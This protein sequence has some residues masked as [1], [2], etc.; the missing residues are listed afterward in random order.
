[1]KDNFKNLNESERLDYLRRKSQ[2]KFIAGI[3]HYSFTSPKKDD[4]VILIPN[5]VNLFDRKAVQVHN[6]KLEQM[7]H[8]NKESNRFVFDLLKGQ[9]AYAKIRR[10]DVYGTKTTYILDLSMI[11]ES[12]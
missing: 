9:P 11:D 5:P 7:G 3:E 4:L 8:L 1:M 10:I 12:L 2:M 6:L